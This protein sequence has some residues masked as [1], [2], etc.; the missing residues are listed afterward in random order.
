[1]RWRLPLVPK[2]KKDPRIATIYGT[3]ELI[4]AGMQI[5]GQN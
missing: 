1:M 5:R 4:K 3:G 2:D